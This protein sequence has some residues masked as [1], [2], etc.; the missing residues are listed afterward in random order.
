[1]ENVEISPSEL[2]F[3]FALNK[4]LLGSITINNQSDSRVA[5]KVK[6]TAPKK[7]ELHF[8][9]IRAWDSPLVDASSKADS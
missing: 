6:T 1:M 3:R 4:Q 5:F 9:L 2:K 8:G 7:V